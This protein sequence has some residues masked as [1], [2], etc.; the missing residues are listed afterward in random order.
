MTTELMVNKYLEK[1]EINISTM[2][3]YLSIWLATYV[4]YVPITSNIF[5]R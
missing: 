2:H 5:R 4:Q 1:G 3:I